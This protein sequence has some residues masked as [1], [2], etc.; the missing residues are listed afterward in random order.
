MQR[1]VFNIILITLVLVII[2]HMVYNNSLFAVPQSVNDPEYMKSL[3]N[4]DLDPVSCPVISR[5][6]GASGPV[7]SS[8]PEAKGHDI[9]IEPKIY[10]DG[11]YRDAK[12]RGIDR[13]NDSKR[14]YHDVNKLITNESDT[15]QNDIP[16]LIRKINKHRSVKIKTPDANEIKISSLNKTKKYK[17]T[18]DDYYNGN[19]MADP[20]EIALVKKQVNSDQNASANDQDNTKDS[21]DVNGD[22]CAT[23]AESDQNIKRYIREYVL[24]GNTQCECVVDKSKSDFTRNEVDQY[25]EQQIRFGDKINGTSSP[26]EDPVDKMNQITMQGI[27]ATGQTI[28]SFYDNI[29]GNKVTD[30]GATHHWGPVP[31]VS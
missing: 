12:T 4:D 14:W 25:R 5:A 20:Y 29:V 7:T 3:G 18:F 8:A 23:F 11:K 16:E 28:A 9:V 30:P 31:I 1:Y 15:N 17:L 27:K 22:T 2:L 21:V 26:A 10:N 19:L 13:T 24:D 6:P